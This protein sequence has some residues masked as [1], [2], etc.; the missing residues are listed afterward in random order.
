MEPAKKNSSAFATLS[1]Q[2]EGK[3]SHFN[4]YLLLQI[5]FFCDYKKS[6]KTRQK[7]KFRLVVSA[8]NGI[9]NETSEQCL[10]KGFRSRML[11]NE[12]DI[13]RKNNDETTKGN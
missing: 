13:I 5:T 2:K 9:K 6:L 10:K 7:K 1:S 4:E 11:S 8:R 12:L 3:M